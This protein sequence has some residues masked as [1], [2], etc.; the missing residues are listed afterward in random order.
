MT[1]GKNKSANTGV[2]PRV[3]LSYAR[4]DG[5]RFAAQ[6]RQQLQAEHIPL[7]QDRVGMEGGRDWWQQIT[8]A[9]DV[10]EFMV[11]VMTPAAMLSEM[12]RK[13][14]R[15]AR[16][17]GVCVYPVKG[18][19]EL[20]FN[21]LPH[22]MRSA[23]FYDLDHE[24]PKLFNDL[25]TRCQQA[26][27][28]FMVEDLPADYVPRP[29]EFGALIDKLLDQR[30]EEPVAITAALRGA[31]GYGKTTMAKALCHDERI[32]Q[33]FDDGILWVTL[34]EHPGNL[35]GK[36]EDLIYMLNQERPGFTG[37]DAAGARLAELLADRDILLVVDDVWD[38]MHLKP[39]LQGGKRCARLVTTRNEDVLPAN[40]QS[41]VVD[42][43]KTDEAV[44]LLSSG[45]QTAAF[46]A[47]AMQALRALVARLGEWA[48]LLKLANGVLRDRVG[49]GEALVNA[50]AYL[51]KALDRRG[52][53]AFDAQN[54]QDRNAAVGATLRVSFELLQ[55][56][57]Y[58]R[59][60]E[61]AVFPEDVDI[62]LAILQKLWGATGGLDEFDTEELCQMLYQHSLLL[63]FD[64]AT[65]TIR[66]HD[67][68]RS[69][70][71]KAVG[72]A[73]PALHAHL[74]DAYALTR[75][76]D[77]PGNESYLWDHLAG[78]LVAAGRLAELVA[79]VKDLRYLAH[80]TLARTAY[81]TEADLAFA[82]QRA[83]SDVSLRLLKRNV[84]NMGHLLN[85]CTTFNDL[86]AVLYNRL[87]YLKDLSD[88]CQAFE[89]EIPR[90]YLASWHPLP[91]LPDPALIRTFG[92]HRGEVRGCAIS[93]AG[94][95][96]V[97]AS[98]DN[99]LKVWDART[100]EERLTL[101][102][103]TSFVSG[104]AISPAGDTIVSASSDETLKVWDARTGEELRTL[105]GHTSRVTGCAISPA[106]DSIV[107][108]SWDDTLK[109]W[110][111][112]TGACLS[113]LYVN[114]WL[115]ACAFHPDRE[116][117][118][119]AGGGGVYFL[120]WVR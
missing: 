68:I 17:Q 82:E 47:V 21:S 32:Q 69:Y 113:T 116:H 73:L 56:E 89:Q 29:Q 70:L 72:A 103:H 88:L 63:T 76:A 83:P 114:G 98:D 23:H 8:E 61:L 41:L 16:Q 79:T 84:A 7:W 34:G 57:Q 109:V 78:H 46:T 53:T 4:I 120:R 91:D 35:V 13:E 110:D 77:L 52:L 33:A 48:L 107:S 93:P 40:T 119:A 37:I 14:W 39:F 19:P 90:P 45:L 3:F 85:R 5:E 30:R 108:A 71:Q 99:T 44:Q 92:G 11:L 9:L 81:A 97:S 1:A 2:V 86:A 60:Q 38:S 106:G 36:V 101:R 87:A 25:N 28:P 20:D 64:L 111:A 26:H 54:A 27:V 80:K 65:R 10:V 96:I 18:A 66:L 100:G 118:I 43:M 24:W 49:R 112:R 94:D 67:V 51:N 42:A 95:Y 22:W 117:I 75:W 31:G 62:P 12:V 102:G 105:R 50:L 115:N 74:L 58:A 104:C 55:A 59:Y 6:L 15:Y